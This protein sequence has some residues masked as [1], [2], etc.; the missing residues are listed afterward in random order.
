MRVGEMVGPMVGG[1]AVDSAGMLAVWMAGRKDAIPVVSKVV[2]LVDS[3]VVQWAK[4]WGGE[5][6]LRKV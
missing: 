1:W 2:C 3:K 6:E 4:K 5:L